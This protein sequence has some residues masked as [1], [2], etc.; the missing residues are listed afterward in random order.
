MGALGKIGRTGEHVTE[1]MMGF[2]ESVWIFIFI[3]RRTLRELLEGTF[4]S[5]LKEIN[6]N[7]T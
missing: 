5:I 3:R 6:T 4:R 1:S 7:I 2:S